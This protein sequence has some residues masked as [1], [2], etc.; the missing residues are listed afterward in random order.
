MPW[1][2]AMSTR[3]VLRAS[4]TAGFITRAVLHI[5]RQA[6]LDCVSAWPVECSTCPPSASMRS[7]IPRM[8]LPSI[9]NP[10]RPSSSIC[11]MQSPFTRC[12]STGAGSCLS[13]THYIG[14]RLAH[15]QRQHAFLCGTQPNLPLLRNRT[16]RPQ[17]PAWH[18]HVPFLRTVPWLD[19]REWRAAL[20]PARLAKSSLHHESHSSRVSGSRSISF[21]ANSDFNTITD[22]VCPR[23]IVQVA[24]NA[25]PLR[26]FRKMFH[27]FLRHLQLACIPLCLREVNIHPAHNQYEYSPGKPCSQRE[28][29]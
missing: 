5:Q 10:P 15:Y 23:H 25:L 19:S 11:N 7:R 17:F 24:R 3:I 26:N 16:S 12:N 8:P 2:S 4:F 14:H 13:V 6:D 21:D 29:E 9:W 28:M 22:S 1:S 27:F 18:E 20:R